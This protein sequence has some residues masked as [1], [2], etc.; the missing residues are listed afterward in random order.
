MNLSKT[1]FV[2]SDLHTIVMSFL[3]FQYDKNSAIRAKWDELHRDLHCCGWK[4][5]GEGYQNFV[6]VL[7]DSSVPD[8]C[9]HNVQEGCGKGIAGRYDD[10]IRDRIFVDGCREILDEKLKDDVVPMMVVY[11]CVGV[12]LA[13]VE[14]ISV[15]LACAYVAQINR[16]TSR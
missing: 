7:N 3:L 4:G 10:E 2:D 11:A 12:I 8:S 16:R 6:S 9:C 13:I 5:I 1:G 14:L 15:V